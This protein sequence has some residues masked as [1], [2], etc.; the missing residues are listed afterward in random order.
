VTNA[1]EPPIPDAEQSPEATKPARWKLGLVITGIVIIQ[2]GNLIANATLFTLIAKHPLWLIF[3]QPTTKNLILIAGQLPFA[4]FFFVAVL[5]RQ[6]PHVLWWQI[7]RWYGDA[8]IAWVKKK[9]PEIATLLQWLEEKFPKYGWLICL[10][11]PHP[12]VC[13]LAGA[14]SMRFIPFL[15]FTFI[16]IIGYVWAAWAG[17]DLLSPVVDPITE[18]SSNNFIPLTVLT[19]GI[20]AFLFWQSNRNE[21]KK[22]ESVH[23]M[24]EELDAEFDKHIDNEIKRHVDES[25][26][27]LPED[28][29]ETRKPE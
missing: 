13:A 4:V 19:V 3:L 2:I 17:A 1:E 29:R 12:A 16:G 11:Y 26:E 7:G 15:I 8:G 5:R 22:I 18:F 25:V 6:V 14:S 28:D 10:L 21:N 24:E 20:T 23:Q 9:S 27:Q